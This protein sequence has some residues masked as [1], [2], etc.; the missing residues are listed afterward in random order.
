MK[1]P[2][3]VLLSVGV[4]FGAALVAMAQDDKPAKG[5]DKTLKGELGCP[6]CVFKVEGV[7]ACGNAIKVTEKGEEVIYVFQ[8]K[9][10]KEGY[11]KQICTEGKKGSVKGVVAKK[12]DKF[13]IKPA[14]GGVKF[15]D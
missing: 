12:G 11:H 15:E 6:K 5:A 10:A 8:D 14:K 7:K 3:K 1:T 13:F 4:L 2:V 9:G